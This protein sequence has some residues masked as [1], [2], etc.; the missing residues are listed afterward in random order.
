MAEGHKQVM[1]LGQ[2]LFWIVH[3][4]VQFGAKQKML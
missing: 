3:A 2:K 4:T 1:H